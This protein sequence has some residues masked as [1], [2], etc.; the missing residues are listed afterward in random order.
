MIAIVC[1]DGTSMSIQMDPVQYDQVMRESHTRR[2]YYQWPFGTT[3]GEYFRGPTLDGFTVRRIAEQAAASAIK[4]RR[5]PGVTALFMFGHS[6]GCAAIIEAAK[7]LQEE[8]VSVEFVGFF[9]GVDKSTAVDATVVPEN[10]FCVRHARRDPEGR[11]RPFWGNCGTRM[12]AAFPMYHEEFFYC[13]HGAVGGTPYPAEYQNREGFIHERGEHLPTK[14]T[15]EEDKGGSNQVWDYMQA[16][17]AAARSLYGK[18]G[19]RAGNLVLPAGA[20]RWSY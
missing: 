4:R 8:N 14:I 15:A 13:T 1:V 18:P 10:V 16:G 2:V 6:R 17:I 7:I 3:C 20:G 11:S 19:N 12:A 5:M 9:D